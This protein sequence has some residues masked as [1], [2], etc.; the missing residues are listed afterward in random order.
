M[1]VKLSRVKIHVSHLPYREMRILA[2]KSLQCQWAL[3]RETR[4]WRQWGCT[5]GR[6]NLLWSYKSLLCDINLIDTGRTILE[7]GLQPIA[8]GPL[9]RGLGWSREQVEVWLI[10]VRNAYMHT[11]CILFLCWIHMFWE[12]RGCGTFLVTLT[13]NKTCLALSSTEI[14]TLSWP[15]MKVGT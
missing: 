14:V 1:F 8:L 9:T 12:T 2:D 3:G 15:T 4:F 5:V 6:V 13:A 7:M 11:V 10:E